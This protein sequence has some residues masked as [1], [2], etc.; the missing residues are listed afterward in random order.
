MSTATIYAHRFD[1]PNDEATGIIGGS[2]PN[3]PSTWKFSIDVATAWERATLERDLPNTR[4]VLMRIAIVMSADCGGP[5]DFLLAMVRRGLGGSSGPEGVVGVGRL[6]LT[7]AGLQ[8]KAAWILA[9]LFALANVYL[10]LVRPM[11]SH[12]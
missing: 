9:I 3:A 10:L 7:L 5:F 8:L 2:E 1:A 11:Y 4:R 12:E 6:G